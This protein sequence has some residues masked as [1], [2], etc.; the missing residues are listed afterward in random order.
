MFVQVPGTAEMIRI[1]VACR[2]GAL[3]LATTTVL[4]DATRSSAHAAGPRDT[5]LARVRQERVPPA[6]PTIPSMSEIEE[7]ALD[8]AL[9]ISVPEDRSRALEH[10]AQASVLSGH[11]E[12]G[13]DILRQAGEAT[14]GIY[15][16]LMRDM[17]LRS[18]VMTANNLSEISTR[19]ALPSIALSGEETPEA[20]RERRTT[21]LHTARSANQIAG[22]FAER[23]HGLNYRSEMMAAVVESI[24]RN[25]EEI[26]Q[27]LIPLSD[28]LETTGPATSEGDA[29]LNAA[30]Q[31]AQRIPQ[32][33]WRNRELVRVASIAAGSNRFEVARLVANGIPHALSRGEALINVAESQARDNLDVDA[34]TSYQDAFDTI[35][36]IPDISP[37]I[38]LGAVL[39]DSLLAVGR[40]EDA[41]LTTQVITDPQLKLRA[42]GAIARSMGERGLA[43]D[44]RLWI[45]AEPSAT[46]RDR[47]RSELA[48][49]LVRWI[50]KANVARGAGMGIDRTILPP[51]PDTLRDIERPLPAVPPEP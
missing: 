21:S 37:R 11:R 27:R 43:E 40:F 42:L 35:L 32:P 26:F 38:S 22:Q 16:P 48:A 13:L 36:N 25:S 51:T 18:I 17:R 5:R 20:A 2:Y 12:R 46:S 31:L 19:E 47:L 44:A 30:H 8:D 39:L 24:L 34:T 23:I 3:L 14:L 49:G 7:F 6:S 1:Q 45:E 50:E 33:V 29:Q 4:L 15:D 10:S 9:R 41:R 28:T